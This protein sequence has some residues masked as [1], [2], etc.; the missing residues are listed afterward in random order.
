MRRAAIAL[1]LAL[2]LVLTFTAQAQSARPYFVIIDNNLTVIYPDG[3]LQPLTARPANRIT[4]WQLADRDVHPSPDGNFVVYRDVPDYAADAW[5]ANQTGNI[6]E[7]PSDLYLIDLR[8]GAETPLAT[9]PGGT[10]WAN[11]AH[12]YRANK[13][14]AAWSP[15][16]RL[17]AYVETS[18]APSRPSTAR[19]IV[20]DI[21]SGTSAIWREWDASLSLSSRLQWTAEGLQQG[22]IRFDMDGDIVNQV[23]LYDDMQALYPV[24]L[25]GHDYVAVAPVSSPEAEGVVHLIDLD[26]GDLFETPGYVSIVA[27]AAPESSLVLLDYTNDTRPAGVF[28]A[29]GHFLFAAT[30]QPPYPVEFVLAPDGSYFAY[31][32]VGQ[33]ARGTLIVDASG[34]EQR[35]DGRMA[36][37]GDDIYT[38]FNPDGALDLQPTSLFETSTACGSLPA[39][40]LVRGGSGIVLGELPNRLRSAPGINATIMSMIPVGETFTVVEGQQGVCRDGIR[41]AQVSYDGKLGWTAERAGGDRFIAPR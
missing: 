25:D 22:T 16:S 10:G 19:L 12:F 21:A 14:T 30:N 35:V 36:A 13:D 38:V 26:T 9:H 27:S 2:F 18:S 17:F 8:T 5:N 32:E 24:R 1:T 3:A 20:Y 28:T 34:T 11:S 7:L 15:D 37:W 6:G 41:W 4:A 31:H 23:Y 33:G 40:G 39:V 29:D